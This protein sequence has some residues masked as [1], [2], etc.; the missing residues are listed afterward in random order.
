MRWA[1]LK[2]YCGESGKYGYYNSQEI[3]L[4][5]A[6]A[7]KGEEIVIVE[8]T[9]GIAREQTEAFETNISVLK[10]PCR[11]LGVH[12]FYRPDFLLEKNI[13]IVQIN[14]DNQIFAPA[15]INFCRKHHIFFYNYIGTIYSDT[16]NVFKKV[17]MG[18]LSRR[19]LSY[20][21][22]S[23]VIAKTSAVTQCLTDKHAADV[24]T[25][26]VGLDTTQIKEDSRDRSD[27]RR[28]LGL[29][30]D[31]TI[32]LF[33]GRLD[34]YKRPFASLEILKAL[35][36]SYHLVIIGD[37]SLTA[38]LQ[39]RIKLERLEQSVSWLSKVPNTSMYQ[40]YR[41]CDWF[42]NL[43]TH[44]IFG[45]SILEAMYQGCAVAARNAPGPKEI[46]ENR[47]SGYLCDSDRE[48]IAAIKQGADPDLG[49]RAA[50]RIRSHFTWD[51]S[52]EQFIDFVNKRKL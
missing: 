35:G 2:L 49:R 51:R 9:R 32:L 30:D 19:N 5:R 23:P 40:Y 37:G 38:E 13:D 16:E 27:I 28:S 10:V 24:T 21:Q 1:I 26:P 33:V 34:P 3:G 52:A 17:L 14:S 20:F 29:P 47:V 12:S 25:I 46:I 39:N 41:A 18:L 42:I 22:K 50:R 31:K 44:E 15:V 36:E 11:T 43:N 4:A 8:P 7:A 48:I 6:L 45:M